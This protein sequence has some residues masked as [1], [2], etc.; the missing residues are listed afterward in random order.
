MVN[1]FNLKDRVV[2]AL[3]GGTSLKTVVRLLGISRSTVYRW[4]RKAETSASL[5]P[6][7]KGGRPPK[8]QSLDTLKQFVR[9]TFRLRP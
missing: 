5:K 8:I 3:D 6:K 4:K 1:L 9:A 2:K 7:N